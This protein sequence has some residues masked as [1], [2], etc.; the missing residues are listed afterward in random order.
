MAACWGG[1]FHLWSTPLGILWPHSNSIAFSNAGARVP[2]AKAYFFE[3]GTTTPRTTYSDAA[4][5]T[6]RTHPVLADGN[7]R[8][9]AIFLDYGDY[10]ERVR[11]AGDTT[12]W[13][14]D[15]IPNPAPQSDEDDVD[16]DALL[17]TGDVFFSF[18]NGTRDGAV[19][20]NGRTIGSATSGATERANP[21]C[22]GLFVYLW[23]N[24]AILA[25]SGGRGATAAA[26][27]LANK[28]IALPDARGSL[29]AGLAD[30]GNSAAAHLNLA[31]VVL[32]GTTTGASIL[33]SNTHQ[34]TLGEMPQHLHAINLTSGAGEAHH[35]TLVNANV[36]GGGEHTHA[37]T[38]D[39]GGVDHTHNYDRAQFVT[40]NPNA[41]VLTYAPGNAG[42]TTSG[43]SA[44]LHTHP[45]S[46]AS[47]GTHFHDIDGNTD[48][49]STHRHNVSGNTGNQGASGFHNNLPRALLGTWFIKL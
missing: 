46:I 20:C 14:T 26:D 41:G 17:V 22:E 43:A 47:S 36:T 45:F 48:N 1:P 37:G 18:R 12:I 33:G 35:H 49:E 28:T 25:V 4:L 40:F 29:F 24:L 2:G 23:N 13:D 27:W 31:P 15:D 3:A 7:G 9:P 19:R 42:A 30:M 44:Y 11:S 10:R 34:L 6:P 16:P 39:L 38:T 32:G 5:T 8:F 21:D